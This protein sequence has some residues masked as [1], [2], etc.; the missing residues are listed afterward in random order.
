MADKDGAQNF[1]DNNLSKNETS[2]QK[3]LNRYFFVCF[4]L[5]FLVF[6][7]CLQFKD[8]EQQADGNGVAVHIIWIMAL[9]S[10]KCFLIPVRKLV[11]FNQKLIY[12]TIM[13]DDW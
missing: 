2:L 3:K 1:L 12:T 11:T 5:L 7:M 13:P 9:S 4:L 6:N 10:P 8:R